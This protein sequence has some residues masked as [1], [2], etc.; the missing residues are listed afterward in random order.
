[1]NACHY[2]GAVERDLRPYGPGG[3]WVCFQCATET[4][5][6]EAAAKAAFGALLDGAEAIS[7]TGVAAIGERGGPR[8]FDPRIAAS[9]STEGDGRT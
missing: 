6:R 7:P 9:P 2:C 4:P 1:V 3:A 5:E 8:P